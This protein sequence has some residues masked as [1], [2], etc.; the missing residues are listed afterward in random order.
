MKQKIRLNVNGKIRK[1]NVDIHQALLEVLRDDLGLTGTKYGCGNGECGACTVLV[2][3]KPIASCLTL[4]VSVEGKDITTIDGLAKD[5]NLHGA[6][7]KWG[8]NPERGR[9]KEK[10]RLI[11]IR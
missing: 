6:Q 5:G 3:G 7:G 9:G 11:F 8:V 4:A 1:L 10:R 2:E